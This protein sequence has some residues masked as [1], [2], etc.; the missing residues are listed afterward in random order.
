[1]TLKA[2]VSTA[3]IAL[4]SLFLSGCVSDSYYYDGYRDSGPS[5]GHYERS[6]V[7]YRTGPRYRSR[8][9]RNDRYYRDAGPRYERQHARSVK[10]SRVSSRDAKPRHRPENRQRPDLNQSAQPQNGI[11]NNYR[12]RLRQNR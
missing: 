4:L 1:M 2:L 10:R 9:H 12:H 11:L 7:I 8:H 3:T 5:Y 6:A